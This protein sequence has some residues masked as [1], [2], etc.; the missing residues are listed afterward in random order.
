MI[1]PLARFV[2]DLFDHKASIFV[3]FEVLQLVNISPQ[4]EEKSLQMYQKS[5]Y[6]EQT[7]V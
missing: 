2:L 5:Y 4:E 6:K 1:S 3:T 7:N